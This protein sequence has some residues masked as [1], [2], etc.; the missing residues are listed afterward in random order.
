VVG[1]QEV[2]VAVMAMV[3]A[4][5]LKDLVAGFLVVGMEAVAKKRKSK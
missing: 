3:L 2:V 5:D 1:G 4:V